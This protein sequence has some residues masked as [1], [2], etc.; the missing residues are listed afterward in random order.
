MKTYV[1]TG[2]TSG[3]GRALVESFKDADVKLILLVRN[4]EKAKTLTEVI[5]PSKL[6]IVRADLEA[7]DVL[8]DALKP[9]LKAD[10]DGFVHC[11]GISYT[12][13]LRK[14]TYERALALMK[15]NFF[16][17]AEILRLLT[18]NKPAAKQFRAVAVSSGAS[19]NGVPLEQMYCASKGALDSFVRAASIE[20]G[21]KNIEV[22]TVQP[23]WV[24]TPLTAHLKAYRGEQGFYDYVKTIQPLGIIPPAEVAET[25]RFLLEKKGNKMTGCAVRIN[26]GNVG[27]HE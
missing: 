24:D 2:G 20:L 15:V 4:E 13:S 27:Q 6:E 23:D 16:S 10:F 22:N 21:K 18:A 5:S 12:Q 7:V 26:A 25:I 19:L 3:I 9:C 8:K 17:F 14:S 1:I 11:A